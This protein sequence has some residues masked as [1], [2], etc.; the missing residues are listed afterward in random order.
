M[1]FNATFFVNS[2]LL[3]VGL[4][5]DAFYVGFTIA[6]YNFLMAL[7]CALIIAVVT[8]AI[9][10]TDLKTLQYVAHPYA[11][12]IRQQILNLIFCVFRIISIQDGVER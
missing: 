1:F 9:C 4:A 5:M 8:F 12:T 7:I 3:G 6:G 2:I 11:I 10:I